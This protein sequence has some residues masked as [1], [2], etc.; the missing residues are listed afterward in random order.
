MGSGAAGLVVLV[1]VGGD[2]WV[3]VLDGWWLVVVVAG[4]GW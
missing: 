1:L 4:G 2:R 3:L